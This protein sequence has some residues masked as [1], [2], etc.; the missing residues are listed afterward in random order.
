[1]VFIINSFKGGI[2]DV[3]TG[4]LLAQVSIKTKPKLSWLEGRTKMSQLSI[5]CFNSFWGKSKINFIF[6]FTNLDWVFISFL[7]SG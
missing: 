3:I 1:L 2:S 7:I 6:D 5:I 4:L